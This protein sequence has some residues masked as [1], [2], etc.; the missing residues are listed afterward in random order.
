MSRTDLVSD[1]VER[2]EKQ[3]LT[4]ELAA[5]EA[6]PSECDLSSQLGVSRSVVR[7]ALGKLAG[8][9]MI[10]S[11]HGSGTWVE[12]PSGKSIRTGIQ[13]LIQRTN[14][15]L[16]K[17]AEVRLP[18]ET[19]IAE[20]AAQ[21]RT[22]EHLEKLEATQLVLGDP[23]RELAD[24][25][26]ADLEFHSTLAEATSNPIFGLMLAPIQELLIQSRTRTLGIHGA[27]LAFRH[28]AEILAAVWI[29]SV[30]AAGDAMKRH[31]QANWEHLKADPTGE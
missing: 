28:H 5:G 17:L 15:R 16:E 11:V 3:I 14:L 22:E 29:S 8:Q 30:A 12:P 20:L 7:E 24:H 23:E 6:L 31:I 13:Q 1:L 2:I 21:M 25:V 4:G 10:R 27:D 19:A 26:Q 18:L 9:G